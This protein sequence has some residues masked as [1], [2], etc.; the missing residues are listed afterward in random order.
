MT[1][2]IVANVVVWAGLGGYVL[3]LAL[4]QKKLARKVRQLEMSAD[5]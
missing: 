1:Y 5:E 3:F 2:L 4:T